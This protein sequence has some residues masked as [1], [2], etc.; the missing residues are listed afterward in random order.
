MGVDSLQQALHQSV[1]LSTVSSGPGLDLPLCWEQHCKL[2]PGV[3][4]VQAS[5]VEHWSVEEVRLT[6]THTHTYIR[7][8]TKQYTQCASQ[9]FLYRDRL[10]QVLILSL[11]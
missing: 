10:Q 5:R 11:I 2:L 7:L 1:F 8:H 9:F 4:G 3:A 6:H